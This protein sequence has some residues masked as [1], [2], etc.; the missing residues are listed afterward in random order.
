MT[1]GPVIVLTCKHLGENSHSM[2]TWLHHFAI[3]I[4]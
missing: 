2:I 3:I 4:N 1:H